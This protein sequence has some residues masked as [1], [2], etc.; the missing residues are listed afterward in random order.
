MR[1]GDDGA[2]NIFYALGQHDAIG[3]SPFAVDSITEPERS[4]V[5]K[6][7]AILAQLA[8]QILAHQGKKAM[9]GFV[10]DK[11]LPGV[12][13]EL[14]AYELDIRLDAIFGF[15]AEIGYGLIIATGPDE[16]LGAGSGF[17]VAFKPTTPGPPLAGILA[18]DEGVFADGKWTPGRRLNG[19]ENDQGRGW[20]FS[21]RQ[22][23]IQRCQ[24]YRY[25]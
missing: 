22:L 16:F 6:S 17:R 9:T 14:N 19:D 20:R 24:A 3:T 23:S 1:R 15:K 10:L 13:A 7:Y 5:S 25:G 18:V 11:D 12:K 2:R 4:S 8:P 21:P